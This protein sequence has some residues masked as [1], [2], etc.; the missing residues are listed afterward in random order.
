MRLTR[1][2]S[3]GQNQ[4]PTEMSTQCNCPYQFGAPIHDPICAVFGQRTITTSTD[5]TC[6]PIQPTTKGG[7]CQ[8]EKVVAIHGECLK[9]GRPLKPRK[10]PP[11]DA[12][13]D[14]CGGWYFIQPQ[15]GAPYPCPE[16]NKDAPPPTPATDTPLQAYHLFASCGCAECERLAQLERET[17]G[18]R[19]ERDELA[20]RVCDECN[21]DGWKYNRVEGRHPCVCVEEAEPYQ[22]LE[23]ELETLRA[24]VARL[25]AEVVR[26]EEEF[27]SV[28]SHIEG[29]H[30]CNITEPGQYVFLIK[31]F[32]DRTGHVAQFQKVTPPVLQEGEQAIYPCR[33]WH[34][35]RKGKAPWPNIPFRDYEDY[36]KQTAARKEGK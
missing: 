12:G 22:L 25:K 20:E 27:I 4:R 13:C 23:T 15:R 28:V 3:T 6:D 1:T 14:V 21:G 5:A 32:N 34:E 10:E 35:F 24:D 11:G 8:C 33:E 16:C 2:G 9:C 36:Q 29:Q 17:E 30:G 26:K 7:F 18:L 19:K 31:V